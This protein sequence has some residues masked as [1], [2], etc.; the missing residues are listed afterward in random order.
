MAVLGKRDRPNITK[1]RLGRCLVL[2]VEHEGLG[3]L[4]GRLPPEHDGI[5][6]AKVQSASNENVFHF[7]RSSGFISVSR[8]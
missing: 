6:F 2:V 3:P 5:H 8:L 7:A 1:L 4:Y